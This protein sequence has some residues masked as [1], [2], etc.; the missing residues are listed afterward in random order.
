MR[1]ARMLRDR[2]CPAGEVEALA[3]SAWLSLLG[4]VLWPLPALLGAG[5]VSSGRELAL[6]YLA[7]A[8]AGSFSLFLLRLALRRPEGPAAGS[9]WPSALTLAAALSS[10]PLVG[11]AF[12]LKVATHHRPLGAA[13]FALGAVACFGLLTLLVLSALELRAR[14]PRLGSA[15]VYG[16]G[17][18]GALSAAWALFW[19]YRSLIQRATPV[20]SML[21][22]C[23]GLLL[24][25]AL[26]S[27]RAAW[28]ARS[29]FVLAGVPLSCALW[30]ASLW[31]VRYDLDVRAT[32]KSAPIVAGLVGMVAR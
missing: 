9:R 19:L 11:L 2:R 7:L 29:R 20:A 17:V 10:A 26:V 25:G 30:L 8:G 18:A 32:V 16:A 31:L 15:L 28:L 13:T 3:A 5:H 14:R 6:G 1:A 21:D 27:L 24:A 4:G 23:L 12:A 22:V